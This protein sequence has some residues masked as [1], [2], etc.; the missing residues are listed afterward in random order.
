MILL[1]FKASRFIALFLAVLL[2][3]PIHA[4]EV[5][6]YDFQPNQVYKI[7]TALGITTQIEISPR[8]EIKDYSTGYSN[9]WD[10]ARRDN[11]FYIKPKDEHVDTNMH[12]RTAA[13]NYII[14]LEVVSS[15]WKTLSQ[16]KNQGV[17]YKVSFR[18][19]SDTDFSPLETG[20]SGI[21]TV[22][23]TRKNYNLN[24]D[25]SANADSQWLVPLR[26]YDDNKF[27][28]IQMKDLSSL[29]TGNF[30]TIYGRK[31]QNGEEF[32]LNTNVENEN[33]IVVHGTYS[34]LVIRHGNNVVGLRRN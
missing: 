5:Q 8:E 27:T 28:Y 10:L 7:R 26:V 11:V 17:Q 32:V 4:Q 18:Y 1:K 14:E 2:C 20:N 23:D 13:H 33:F 22:I 9:G 29:P 30:P 16:A 34:F 25:F 19:P 6:E 3:E 31:S 12:I 21:N 24:Y 15:K